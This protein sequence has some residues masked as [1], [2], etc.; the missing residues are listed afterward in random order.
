MQIYSHIILILITLNYLFGGLYHT[1]SV[2]HC[3]TENQTDIELMV[4]PE[5]N[6]TNHSCCDDHQCNME[7]M[8]EDDCC[9]F[10]FYTVNN[11]DEHTYN[12]SIN[13]FSKIIVTLLASNQY[14]FI[15]ESEHNYTTLKNFSATLH[16]I[17][18]LQQKSC[19]LI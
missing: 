19:L 3:N 2:H 1:F 17:S 6:Q 8:M 13:F 18:P 12:Q 4:L 10:D 7:N 9:S 14:A 16:S 15:T 11:I 5:N